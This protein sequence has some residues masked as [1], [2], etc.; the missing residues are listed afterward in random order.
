MLCIDDK[1]IEITNQSFYVGKFTKYGDEGYNINFQLS[2]I[3]LDSNE[4]GYINLGAGFDKDN[5]IEGFLNK[6]YVGTPYDHSDNQFI[7]FEV[8]DTENFWDTEI[9]SKIEIRIE[10]IKDDRL[11][12][13]FE[14]NDE[15]IKIKFDGYL[16]RNI[17]KTRETFLN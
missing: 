15:L 14:V 6:V 5:S 11:E 16:C 2:F 8:Y 12:V 10:D 7:Y 4:N 3:N 13:S 1:K 9:E 17:D